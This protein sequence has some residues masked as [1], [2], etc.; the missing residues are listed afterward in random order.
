MIHMQ[1]ARYKAIIALIIAN[2][3]WGGA[4]PIFKWSL[5]NI[6]PFTLAF[7]RFGLATLILFPIVF[8]KFEKIDIVDIPKIF[9]FALSG[10]TINITFFFLGLRLAPAINSAII[11]T[12]QPLVLL[13]LGAYLL[14]ENVQKIEITGTLVSFLGVL[15]I[16]LYPLLISG[17][18]DGATVLGNFFFILASLGAVGAAFFGK[19]IFKKY[20]SPPITWISFLVGAMTFLPL[21]FLEWSTNPNWLGNLESA[22]I[23]GIIYGA[24][25]SSALAYSLY[26]WG[27]SQIE[28]SETG[29][30]TYLIPITSILIAVPFFGEKITWPFIVGASLVI[31][32]ILLTERRLPYHPLHKRN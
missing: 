3:V 1:S 5:T 6:P 11:A 24:F 31:I 21:M 26:D 10:I 27:L 19:Q 23:F 17:Y 13:V 9:I 32:G 7:L 18:Q 12:S 4:S 22:G 2:I 25:L 16:T 15:L 14:K 8:R 20:P 29:I 30:F 28:A